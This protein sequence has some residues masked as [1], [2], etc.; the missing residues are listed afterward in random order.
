MFSGL[1]L[2]YAGPVRPLTTA[3]EELD[4]VDR[5]LYDLSDIS[6]LFEG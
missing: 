5:D 1:D 2:Y 3:G 6:D 4:H